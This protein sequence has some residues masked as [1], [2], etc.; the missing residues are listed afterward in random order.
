M[1]SG[2]TVEFNLIPQL[3]V[4]LA[5]QTPAVVLD[6]AKRV[7]EDSQRRVHVKTGACRASHY[8]LMQGYTDRANAYGDAMVR[9]PGV[10]M[11][12]EPPTPAK[13]EAMVVVGVFY[14]MMLEGRY[15]YLVPAVEAERARF[16]AEM[17]KTAGGYPAVRIPLGKI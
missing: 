1:K 12:T 13:N 14:G 2:C 5:A 16:Y 3:S 15:P 8:I 6:S 4:N 10:H 7:K 9:R 11:G 17:A